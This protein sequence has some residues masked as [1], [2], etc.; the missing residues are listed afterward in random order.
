M[1]VPDD[2]YGSQTGVGF[3]AIAIFYWT[4]IRRLRKTEY[5][6]TSVGSYCLG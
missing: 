2:V 5:P 4:A 1:A 6:R 3:V